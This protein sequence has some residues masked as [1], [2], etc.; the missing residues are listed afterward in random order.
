M[1]AHYFQPFIIPGILLLGVLFILIKVLS[2]IPITSDRT[3]EYVRKTLHISMGSICLSFPWIFQSGLV[4][5]LLAFLSTSILCVIRYCK[6]FFLSKMKSV[7]CSNSRLSYGEFYFPAAVAITFI[8]SGGE[9]L[10]YTVPIA[11]LTFADASSA[12][13]GIKYGRHPFKYLPFK[14][15]YEGSLAFFLVSFIVSVIGLAAFS[16]IDTRFILMVSAM[17]AVFTTLIEALCPVGLDN[18]MVPLGALFIL[19]THLPMSQEDLVFRLCA[20]MAL[21]FLLLLDQRNLSLRGERIK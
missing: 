16:D 12:L 7:I 17:V 18:L 11:I 5:S 3:Q 10:L 14:K 6:G 20:M 8:L 13:F 9:P 4:V 1:I 2:R 21:P 15:S 19:K